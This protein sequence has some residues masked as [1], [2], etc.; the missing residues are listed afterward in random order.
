MNEVEWFSTSKLEYQYCPNPTGFLFLPE[1]PRRQIEKCKAKQQSDAFTLICQTKQW[2][3]YV[4]LIR[5]DKNE[6]MKIE[7]LHTT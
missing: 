4:Q 6:Y 5:K 1:A 2:N 3:E 7:A